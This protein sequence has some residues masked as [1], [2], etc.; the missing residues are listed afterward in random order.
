MRSRRTIA[1]LGAAA[2]AF[3]TPSIVPIKALPG[4]HGIFSQYRTID[5]AYAKSSDLS[6][7]RPKP[8]WPAFVV[9]TGTAGVFINAIYI[10]HTQ[11]RE[12]SSQEA[13]TSFVSLFAILYDAQASKCH[14]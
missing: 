1:V 2:L 9:I 5:T 7:L 10:W 6:W 11:C 14:P 13:M 12:L 3:W 8:S 4:G